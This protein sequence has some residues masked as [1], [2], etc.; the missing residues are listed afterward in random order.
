MKGLTLTRAS[1]VISP[2]KGPGVSFRCLELQEES[3]PV[4]E[5]LGWLTW[6]LG[7]KRFSQRGGLP[8]SGGAGVSGTC[9]RV[10]HG[11]RQTLIWT[12]FVYSLKYI[13]ITC[14]TKGEF[15]W[16]QICL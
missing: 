15:W 7:V 14:I 6:P 16:Y 9:K 11:G 10:W 8:S 1:E 2:V 12:H 5:I 13:E 4:E 3:F